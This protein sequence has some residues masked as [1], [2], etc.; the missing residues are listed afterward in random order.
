MHL[1][2]LDTPFLIVDLD[3]LEDNLDR[4]Q[5]YFDEHRIAL[6][7]HVKTH[8][9]L[10]IAHRQL[11]RGA[12]GI[13]CQK[14]G[15]AEVMVAGGAGDD[16]LVPYNIVGAAKLERLV[17][18]A[19]QV[20]MT[21]AADAADT[22]EGLSRAARAG[23]VRI[24]VVVELDVGGRAGVGTAAQAG[25]LARQ[26]HR[27]EGLELRGVMAMPTPPSV[28]PL[29]QETLAGFDRDGLPHPVV[30]G[31]STAC[32]L[33]A[34]EI[35]ELTEF[36]AGE[37][38]VGGVSHLQRGTHS[39]AQCCLRVLMTVVSRPTADRAILDGGSKALSAASTEW[40]G[41]SCMGYLVEYPQ[42]RLYGASE[43]HGHV[44]VS[45]CDPQPRIGERVQVLPVH[46][47][48]CVN[49]HD[50]MAAVRGGWVEALWPVH[51]RGRIR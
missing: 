3:G 41:R 17:R 35:P 44:D 20:R 33:Q 37:Y 39:V 48:P 10:A 40:E 50:E 36:R 8:K 25:E 30:S 43:E 14:L 15:E 2:D 1:D 13:T 34:H 38:T 23:G 51:A 22:V 28:R 4:Y 21:V 27:S 26:I 6:R 7:P 16:V 31:G 47:C 24:G 42:A 19:R 5:R 45:A 29:L 9:C 11:R 18:L 32:A 49:E 46:P 12:R